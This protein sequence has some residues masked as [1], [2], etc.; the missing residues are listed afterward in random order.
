MFCDRI[1][2]NARLA[3]LR[4]DRPGI[5][6]VPDGIVACRDSRIV[7]AGAAA[8]APPD[9]VGV[10]A[11]RLRRPLDHAGADRLSYPPDPRRRPLE[12][13]RAALARREL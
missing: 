6:E 2:L 10:R 7:Y 13:I 8:D 12:R 9:L 1:W 4:S 5:G 3:T 11:H